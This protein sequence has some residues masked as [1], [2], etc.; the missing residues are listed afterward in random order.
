M[1]IDYKGKDQ[2]DTYVQLTINE[3]GWVVSLWYG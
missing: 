3:L 1:N 2:K